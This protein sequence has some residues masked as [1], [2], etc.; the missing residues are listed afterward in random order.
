MLHGA[1]PS[2]SATR[3]SGTGKGADKGEKEL[4]AGIRRGKGKEIKKDKWRQSDMG[5]K[6]ACSDKDRKGEAD[7]MPTHLLLCLVICA[8]CLVVCTLL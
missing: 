8:S 5:G 2:A 3:A 6:G 4:E 1:W 7:N